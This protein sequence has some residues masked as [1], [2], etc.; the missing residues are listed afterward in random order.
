MKW[1]RSNNR[2][3]SIKLKDIPVVDYL[4]FYDGVCEKLEEPHIHVASYFAHPLESELVFFCLLLDDSSGE[5][6]IASHHYG[7]YSEESMHS[8]A[9]RYPEMHV[10]ERE[11]T[12]LHGVKFVGSPWDKPLRYP[13]NRKQRKNSIENYPFY[14]IKGASLH[15][16]NVG[17][18]HAG[19]IEPGVF[20]FI[21]NGEK[22]L[23][24][25]I[26]LGYQHRGLERLMVSA[27]KRLRQTVLA[28]S[29]AGDSV[30]AHTS[31]FAGIIE[32]LSPDFE[33][34]SKLDAERA[35][36]LEL[37]RIAVHIADTGAL[38]ADIGYQLGQVASEALR[39]IVINTTQ[40]WCGNRFAKGLIRPHGT[41]FLLDENVAA[42]IVKNISDVKRRYLEVSEDLESTSSLLTRF[43]G[44][45]VMNGANLERIGAVGVAAKAGG[46]ERDIRMSHPWGVWGDKIEHK[47]HLI[48]YGD[49]MARLQMRI[50][51]V[52]Q[53]SDYILDILERIMPMDEMSPMPEYHNKLNGSSLAYSLTE[54]WR[55]EICHVALTD[56]EGNFEVYKIKDPS[57]H[58]WLALALAVRGEEISDF[59]I[60]NKSF[61]LS[62]CGHD[63]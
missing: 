53:S 11:I 40:F 18:I 13:H 46:V 28:E 37:E 19:I 38:C 61:S 31:A 2:E 4:D 5:V 8:I 52:E 14:S 21:C 47:P 23:H 22:V 36:A 26:V 25:E 32:K 51:E 57:M 44:C 1:Y 62:Y 45:G 59:P 49:V 39:T 58:N 41:N 27:D 48:E 6:L 54:G 7:Y 50:G 56:E 55:G 15:E 3:G 16:V 12:E 34:S 43:E 60:C 20:R 30:V 42:E 35:V 24:L 17:P 33:P 29:I 10:F 9:A 63:L